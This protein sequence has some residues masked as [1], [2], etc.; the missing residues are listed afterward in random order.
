MN[1][2]YLLCLAYFLKDSCIIRVVIVSEVDHPLVGPMLTDP[3]ECCS[4]SEREG[5]TE[6]KRMNEQK[7]RIPGFAETC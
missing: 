4:P 7:K 6:R 1:H 2:K 5:I 3:R